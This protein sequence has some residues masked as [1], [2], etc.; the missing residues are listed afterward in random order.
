M[1]LGGRPCAQGVRREIVPAV[2]LAW[3]ARMANYARQAGAVCKDGRIAAWW[4]P[5]PRQWHR[6][7]QKRRHHDARAAES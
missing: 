4:Q 6:L 7:E 2:P 1:S 3:N 5:T